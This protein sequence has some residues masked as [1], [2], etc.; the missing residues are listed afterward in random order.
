MS[1]AWLSLLL[2]AM[3]F[4]QV[5]ANDDSVAMVTRFLSLL[6]SDERMAGAMLTGDFTI[7]AGDVGGRVTVAELRQLMHEIAADCRLDRLAPS[8]RTLPIEPPVAIV[9]AQYH[10]VTQA[11]PEGHDMAIDY[12]VAGNRIGGMYMHDANTAPAAQTGE[13]GH[14]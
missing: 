9:S 6:E 8:Q 7:A 2:G 14:E 3:A 4:M 11:R 10:C 5:P 13:A 1:V 12:L